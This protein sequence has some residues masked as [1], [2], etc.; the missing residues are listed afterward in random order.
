MFVSSIFGIDKYGTKFTRAGMEKGKCGAS[1]LVA[2]GGSAAPWLRYFKV[3]PDPIERHSAVSRHLPLSAAVPARGS[4]LDRESVGGKGRAAK[5]ALLQPDPGRSKS[6]SLSTKELEG[7]RCGH[8]SG[9]R[10]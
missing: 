7:I 8:E 1:G 2:A 5:K 9:Y 3:D 4:G 10:S 6:A